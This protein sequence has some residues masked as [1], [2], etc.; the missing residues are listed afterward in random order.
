MY[1]EVFLKI[2]NYSDEKYG[3]YRLLEKNSLWPRLASG[4]E[5]VPE[6]KN[7]EQRR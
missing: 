7:N 1:K 6:C 2:L 4:I 3:S 5:H